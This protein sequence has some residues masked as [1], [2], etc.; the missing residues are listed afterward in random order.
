MKNILLP[1]SLLLLMLGF[2]LPSEAQSS[3][4]QRVK[5]F[6][7]S[8]K[9]AIQ[10]YDPVAYFSQQKA[11]KG[12]SEITTQYQGVVYQFASE[13][14]RK[15]FIAN[16]SRFEP[17]YGGW[18]AFAMGDYGKKV[19]VNPETFKIVDDKLYLFYNAFLNNTLKDW[20]EDE[21][22]L[23]TKGDKNWANL[24]K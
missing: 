18:C 9:L 4:A 1:L 14:N 3:E 23:K 15:L 8:G 13:Q 24:I 21:Q 2:S 19:K 16:P 7:L 12:K 17:Q 11:V 6:N 5:H 10:G 20:N 22:N